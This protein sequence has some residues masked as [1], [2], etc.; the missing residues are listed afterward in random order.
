MIKKLIIT[1]FILF[2]FTAC[3]D[4][5][6]VYKTP[7]PTPEV[8]EENINENGEDYPY[9]KTGYYFSFSDGEFKVGIEIAPNTFYSFD[10]DLDFGTGFGD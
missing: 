10:G 9:P 2:T 4:S 6:Y 7:S 1:I 3:V 8:A 5:E